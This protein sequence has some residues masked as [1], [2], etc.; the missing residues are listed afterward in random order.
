MNLVERFE[1]GRRLFQVAAAVAVASFAA[2]VIGFLFEPRPTM[3]SYLVALVYWLGIALGS[4]ILLAIFHASNA[5][6]PVVVRRILE[7]I[8]ASNVVF[9]PLFLPIA[10]GVRLIYLWAA[11]PANLDHQTRVLLDHRSPY[12]NVPF[13][14]VRTAVYFAI[15]VMVA[16]A[17]HAWSQQQDS[18]RDIRLTIKQRR[19]GAIS[20]PFLGLSIT[21]AAFDWLMSLDASWYSTLFGVYYFAGAFVAAIALL[22]LLTVL[23][24]GPNLFGSLVSVDHYHNLGTL[25]FAFVTF[26]GYIAF[27]HFLLVWIADLPEEVHWFLVRTTGKWK[28]VAVALAIGHFV[29]PFFALLPSEVK[30]NRKALTVLAAW[31][32]V[33]CYLDVYWMIFPAFRP[34]S[35]VPHWTTA[36][37]FL[38]V[39]AVP[40]AFTAWTLRGSYTIPVGDPY[41]P[42]SLRFRQP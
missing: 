6:W 3:F 35:P 7:K 41:L 22:T 4:L 10:F 21:F 42:L 8:S 19:L 20:L 25:L 9:V 37:A 11:R 32:L 14:L 5:K 38:F 40:V 36:T 2:T 30:R 17:L 27:C 1:G 39:G 23:A 15:W 29:I 31:V 24:R 34:E 12:L 26:W 28:P 13:F 33:F 16:Y 18:S